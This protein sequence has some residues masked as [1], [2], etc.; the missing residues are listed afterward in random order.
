[1]GKSLVTRSR[2][3]EF[4]KLL[5]AL[6]LHVH[7]KAKIP[8]LNVEHVFAIDVEGKSFQVGRQGCFE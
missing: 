2:L 1:M 3:Y 7:S 4:K 5:L 6:L 8:L